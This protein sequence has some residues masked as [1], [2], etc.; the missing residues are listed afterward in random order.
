MLAPAATPGWQYML[1]RVVVQGYLELE[2]LT[3]N[4]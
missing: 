1:A 4:I 3:D 2:E